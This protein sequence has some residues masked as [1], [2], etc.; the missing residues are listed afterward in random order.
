[1]RRSI[2]MQVTGM[3]PPGM[4][5]RIRKT[6]SVLSPPA[7]PHRMEATVKPARHST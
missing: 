7:R 4:A 5:C 6:T 2:T 1:M 3:T